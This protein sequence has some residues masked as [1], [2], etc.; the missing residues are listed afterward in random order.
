MKPLIMQSYTL[1]AT[2]SLLGPNIHLSTL[3]SNALSLC[4]PVSVR[5]RVSHLYKTRGS[6]LQLNLRIFREETGRQETLK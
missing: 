6:F 5:D 1:L 2:S 4:S 3:C